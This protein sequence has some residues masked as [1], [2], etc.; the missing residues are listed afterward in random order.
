MTV[1]KSSTTRAVVKKSF[2]TF[3]NFSHH[4][5]AG[6]E[7]FDSAQ[8]SQLCSRSHIDSPDERC[9]LVIHF[10]RPEL[11]ER[12]HRVDS[13]ARIILEICRLPA[14][15]RGLP[16]GSRQTDCRHSVAIEHL[17]GL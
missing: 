12:D 10:Y 4:G 16:I 13:S 3:L 7:S 5:R 17:P 8:L 9:I 14:V 11:I 2:N 6:T 15:T 1:V